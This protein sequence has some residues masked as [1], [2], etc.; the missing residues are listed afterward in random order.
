M[1][2]VTLQVP[3]SLQIASLE[4]GSLKARLSSHANH[5]TKPDA[6]LESSVCVWFVTNSPAVTSKGGHSK[7]LQ[8]LFTVCHK[9]DLQVI[10]QIFSLQLISKLHEFALFIS[11]K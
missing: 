6:Y 4:S 5:I 8:K 3:F 1:G 7:H 2:K 10:K 9:K 11:R